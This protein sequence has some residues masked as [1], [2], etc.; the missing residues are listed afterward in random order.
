MH[1]LVEY[2]KEFNKNVIQG[3]SLLML[4]HFVKFG[5]ENITMYNYKKSNPKFNKIPDDI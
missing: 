5:D 4:T 3:E 2:Y 1:Q